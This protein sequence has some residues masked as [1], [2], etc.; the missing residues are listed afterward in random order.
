[1]LPSPDSVSLPKCPL[2][3]TCLGCLTCLVDTCVC[4]ALSPPSLCH[5]K[6]SLCH[7]PPLTNNHPGSSMFIYLRPHTSQPCP[8]CRMSVSNQNAGPQ[9][10]PPLSPHSM[11]TA[12]LP[13]RG[14]LSRW[15]GGVGGVQSGTET[16]P[17][18]LLL[19]EHVSIPPPLLCAL[20]HLLHPLDCRSSTFPHTQM[21]AQCFSCVPSSVQAFLTPP[22]GPF[23][24]GH[25]V[26]PGEDGG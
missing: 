10:A 21:F 17:F 5:N 26:S 23:P 22:P 19:E 7:I 13:L 4:L 11:Q 1:M 20:L 2:V 8:P 12:P 24:T 6:P 18:E 9:T 14:Q 15:L 16:T 25:T 3:F